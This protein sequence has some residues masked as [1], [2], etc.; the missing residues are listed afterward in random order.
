M[1]MLEGVVVEESRRE[2][3]EK[4]K[5]SIMKRRGKNADVSR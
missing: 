5:I 2:E 3:R 4:K 1:K